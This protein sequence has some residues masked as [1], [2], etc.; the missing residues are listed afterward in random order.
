MPAKYHHVKKRSASGLAQVKKEKNGTNGHANLQVVKPPPLPPSPSSASHTHT[1]SH[2]HHNHHNHLN[3]SHHHNHGQTYKPSPLTDL[4]LSPPTNL[5]QHQ[6]AT[7]LLE[8]TISRILLLRYE[9][10][11]ARLY[12]TRL[13]ALSLIQI[14]TL[15]LRIAGVGGAAWAAWNCCRS[16]GT[17]TAD[18]YDVHEEEDNGKESIKDFFRALVGMDMREAGER[19]ATKSVL[20]SYTALREF[21]SSLFRGFFPLLFFSCFLGFGAQAY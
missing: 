5:T 2:P 7:A 17:G 18:E 3:H 1:H 21:V 11:I 8:R 4:S 10:D 9:Q 14:P 12:S 15:V 19:V 13:Y 6:Q 16:A 20:W